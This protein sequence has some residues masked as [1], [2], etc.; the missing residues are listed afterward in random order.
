MKAARWRIARRG[1]ALAVGLALAA[2]I[3]LPDPLIETSRFLHYEDSVEIADRHGAPLRFARSG[4]SD[5]RWVPLASMSRDLIDA[6]VAVED[7]RFWEHE[8]VDVRGTF[9]ALVFNFVPGYRWSGA[10]TITQQLV[11]L[12][13]GRPHGVASKG[14]EIARALALERTFSK[15]E[16]LEQY[17]NRLPYGNGIEGVERASQAYFGHSASELTLSEAALLAG[18]PQAPSATEP[19]RHLP[20]AMRRRALVLSRLEALGLRSAE[21]IA[22]ARADEVRVVPTPP[23]P[24]RA[25]RF[26]DVVQRERARG[27]LIARGGSLRTS[28]DLALQDR[29]EQLLEARVRELA[30]RGVENGAAIVIANASGEVLAYV[31]AAR[32]GHDAPGGALDLLRAP[33]QP[34]STLKPFVYGLLF[35]RGGT[36]ASVLDDVATPMT[37]RAGVLYA[38]RDYDGTERGPVRARVALSSSL[39]LAALDAARRVGP[40]RVLARLEALGVRDV[41]SVEEVGAAAVLGGVDVRAVE[42]AEAYVALARG[43]TRVPLR[44]VPGAI[45]EGTEV[46]P[47]DAAAI[48]RDILADGRARAQAFGSDLHVE[49]EGLEIALKTGT[50]TGFRDAWA[51]VFDDR[52]TVLVWLGD[53]DGGATRA[54]SGFEGAAPVAARLFAAAHARVA[55]LGATVETSV[56]EDVALQ[57]ASICAHTGLLAGARCHA[58]VTERFTA[59]TTPT[60]TCDAHAE[61]GAL[62]LPPRYAEWIARVRPADVRVRT[63]EGSTLVTA[64]VVVH[65][66]AGARM[67]AD[68]RRGETRIP[69]RATIAGALADDVEW[70][71][72]GAV[73]R[74]PTWPLRPGEH[75]F[76]AR[77]RGLRSDE[78]RITVE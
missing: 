2:W 67:L 60:R 57:H 63:S 31:G 6:V 50:S 33:R 36:A 24:W 41:P 78:A 75:R 32:R 10:S 53:P 56:R 40:D 69:L 73:W 9:R 20:R 1:L 58:V 52:V 68:P 34:G 49:S 46:M 48:V 47:A 17:L 43:G 70:E 55:S 54:V 62:L 16:I 59:G 22:A 38:P 5:R 12:V 64:P 72:D 19:R 28:L 65:P 30:P 23:R 7:Q 14:V 71:I 42:L 8:G 4:A 18:I 66:R 44:C 3:G 61:D 29:A 27:A 77:A 26:V 74:E 45:E 25:A 51:A 11:K 76:V 21:E 39:N 37:G 13:Y 15:D 35:E